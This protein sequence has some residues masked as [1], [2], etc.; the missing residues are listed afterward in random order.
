MCHCRDW[1]E[2]L[3]ILLLKEATPRL[4]PVYSLWQRL[5][6]LEWILGVPSCFKHLEPSSIV[7]NYEAFLLV[8]GYCGYLERWPRRV[9]QHHLE[10]SVQV[11]VH[12]FSLDSAYNEVIID[13]R[14]AR[15]MS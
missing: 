10:V 7:G 5:C 14:M 13:P 4:I 11:T 1:E 2:R 6:H 15:V 8:G 3:A 9:R 12:D